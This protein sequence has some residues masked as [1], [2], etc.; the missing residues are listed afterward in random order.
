MKFSN[1]SI[2]KYL[3]GGV[4]C[5]VLLLCSC[6]NF[7]KGSDLRKKIEDDIAYAKS[8][9]FYIKIG[10]SK[11]E[12]GQITPASEELYRVTDKINIEF[13]LNSLYNFSKFKIIDKDT[14]KEDSSG[15]ITLSSVTESTNGV[16]KTYKTTA[17]VNFIKQNLLIVPECDIIKDT[18]SPEFYSIDNTPA[19][20]LSRN[21]TNMDNGIYILSQEITDYSLNWIW[22]EEECQTRHFSSL[23]IK[24]SIKEED[25]PWV[26]ICVKEKFFAD[27]IGADGSLSFGQIEPTSTAFV[28]LNKISDSTEGIYIYEGEYKFQTDSFYKKFSDGLFRLEFTVKDS[29]GNESE[30]PVCFYVIK[31]TFVDVSK[32]N[33]ENTLPYFDDSNF[34]EEDFNQ[35]KTFF[36]DYSEAVPDTWAFYSTAPEDFTYRLKWGPDENNLKTTGAFAQYYHPL[37]RENRFGAV[38]SDIDESVFNIIRLEITDKAGATV[39]IEKLLPPRPELINVEESNSGNFVLTFLSPSFSTMDFSKHLF[40]N[41]IQYQSEENCYNDFNDSLSFYVLPERIPYLQKDFAFLQIDNI[42]GPVLK[43]F[44]YLSFSESSELT[45][46]SFKLEVNKAGEGSGLYRVTLTD[47]KTDTPLF[48]QYFSDEISY[49]VCVSQESENKRFFKEDS[50]LLN[51][52]PTE[53]N[54]KVIAEKN[55]EIAE[56]EI[57]TIKET[58]TDN[59]APEIRMNDVS[60]RGLVFNN[61]NIKEIPVSCI[62]DDN[63]FGENVSCTIRYSDYNPGWSGILEIFDQSQVLSLPAFNINLIPESKSIY[64]IPVPVKNLKEDGDYLINIAVYDKFRNGLTQT[65]GIAHVETI[66]S[67]V[68]TKFSPNDSNKLVTCKLQDAW[69]A[70]RQENYELI[71]Y[72]WKNDEWTFAGNPYTHN[73]IN[74]LTGTTSQILSTEDMPAFVKAYLYAYSAYNNGSNSSYNGEYYSYFDKKDEA[75]SAPVY[76][77][78]SESEIECFS[79][80]IIETNSKTVILND[81]PAFV[82]LVSA[83][84]DYGND[85]ARWERFG[86]FYDEAVIDPNVTGQV[87]NTYEPDLSKVPQGEYYVIIAWFADGTSDISSVRMKTAF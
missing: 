19:L 64:S 84:A 7:L 12:H 51:Y 17:T 31:D 49:I 55:G 4:L 53:Y 15:A 57:Y 29:A 58:Q 9:E 21:K 80:A 82:H 77:F 13:S 85:V 38:I 61:K 87:L 50:F 70:A 46:P 37:K 68:I 62:L 83:C 60:Y 56:S 63:S 10:V 28:E 16:L 1:I 36:V 11:N 22:S 81:K 5:I 75:F 2:T 3:W 44:S 86:D 26:N 48:K 30:T 25:S 59:K 39:T 42:Y 47:S 65:I 27:A 66:L 14:K 34:S 18:T 67:P 40:C 32:I 23:Y 76:K 43:N 54:L 20:K 71:V 8:E 6:E 72:Y 69:T 33:F 41:L 74:L 79:K 24:A 73:K 35:Y 78:F 52:S 45:V